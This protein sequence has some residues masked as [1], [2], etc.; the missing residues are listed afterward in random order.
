MQPGIMPSSVISIS[1]SVKDIRGEVAN[2]AS[3]GG[4][5]GEGG[6]AKYLGHSNI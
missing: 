3:N 4:G 5:D 1:F 2:E 6:I